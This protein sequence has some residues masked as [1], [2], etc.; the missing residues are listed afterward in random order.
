MKYLIIVALV[1]QSQS[2]IAM[3]AL[4]KKQSHIAQQSHQIEDKSF[5][6]NISIGEPYTYA[7]RALLIYLD[8]T[9]EELDSIGL[10]LLFA[11]GKNPGP[12][13]ASMHSMK[14]IKEQSAGDIK[15]TLNASWIIKQINDDLVF[16]I[17]LNYLQNIGLNPADVKKSGATTITETERAL[18]LKVNHMEEKT[19][20]TLKF[21]PFFLGAKQSDYFLAALYT[22]KTN[23]SCIFCL[24]SDYTGHKNALPLWSICMGGHGE[25]ARY[26]EKIVGISIADFKAVLD[27]LENKI[28]TRLFVYVSCYAADVNNETIYKAAKSP[29]QETYSFPIITQALTDA[30]V[31][32]RA[33]LEKPEKFVQATTIPVS[34][35]I[36]YGKAMQYL[37]PEA[38]RAENTAQIKFPGTEWFSVINADKT[39]VQIGSILAENRGTRPL[40]IATFFKTDPRILLLYA[41]DIPFELIINAPN[42]KSIVSM[43]PG[44]VTHTIAKITSSSDTATILDWFMSIE[45]LNSEKIFYIKSI[46]NI[47]DVIICN[48][49]NFEYLPF[50]YER[51]AFFK[52]DNG[53]L[54]VKECLTENGR[55]PQKYSQQVNIKKVDATSYSTLLPNIA[56]SEKMYADLLNY[57]RD[58]SSNRSADRKT[59]PPGLSGR[60]KKQQHPA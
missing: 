29:I 51:F 27:F 17:P 18:G 10:S 32:S 41:Q 43:I 21:F 60:G 4:K 23:T 44:D 45:M 58:L 13:V 47:K 3:Q 8:D 37:N 11:I 2:I 30:P 40:D 33:A 9:E 15:E 35:A 48:I 57:V 42:L 26:S 53:V 28:N 55:V 50:I 16:L 12:I 22:A 52:D 49:P 24:R 7:P 5:G 20:D 59:L 14:M 36:D 39:V 34:D 25:S 38:R 54:F 46:N 56:Y 31:S 1:I 6:H 19:L